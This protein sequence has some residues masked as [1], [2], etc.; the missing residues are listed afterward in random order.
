MAE[1]TCETCDFFQEQIRDSN[2]TGAVLDARTCVCPGHD[3]TFGKCPEA[4][5]PGCLFH[6]ELSK[7]F[8]EVL[9]ATPTPSLGFFDDKCRQAAVIH[10][11][12]Y[13]IQR[14]VNDFV[15]KM[16]EAEDGRLAGYPFNTVG[17]PGILNKIGYALSATDTNGIRT[18]L[19]NTLNDALQAYLDPAFQHI[20]LEWRNNVEKLMGL[21][22]KRYAPLEEEVEKLRQRVKELED[23]NSNSLGLPSGAS[24]ED[25]D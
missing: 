7:D 16:T 15:Q 1:H 20:N 2:M 4:A 14:Y 3:D 21:M 22:E 5:T 23:E 13:A 6:T 8:L 9:A 18:E 11:I 19:Y 25:E 10:A 12:P 17:T 24:L